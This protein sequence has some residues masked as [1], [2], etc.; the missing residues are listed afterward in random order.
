MLRS[1]AGAVLLEARS[2]AP[3]R[4][5]NPRPATRDGLEGAMWFWF[6]FLVVIVVLLLGGG[7][8]YGYRQSYYGVVE[9]IALIFVVFMLFWIAIL[10]I[11][12]YWGWYGWWW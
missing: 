9:L 3:V 10:F 7:S 11:G 4:G 8:Y 1:A 12:P 2:A 6:V 5:R